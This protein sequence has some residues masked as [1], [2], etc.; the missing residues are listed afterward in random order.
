[1]AS[2]QHDVGPAEPVVV[3]PHPVKTMSEEEFV[4]WCDEDTRAEWVDGEVVV[5]SP[6]NLV[7]CKLNRFLLSV[8][9]DFVDARSL[10]E[11]VGTEFSVRLNSKRRRLPDVLF[12]A[13][14][15]LGNLSNTH[16]EGPPSLIIEIVSEDSVDR[17]WRDKYL[18]YQASGMDEY[19][20]VDPL[21]RRIQAYS[22]GAEKVY[23]GIAAVDG[24]IASTVVPGFYLRPEWLWQQPRSHVSAVLAEFLGTPG[25]G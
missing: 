17:D 21:Y 11:V 16:F 22:L 7:H 1:M 8:L 12:V 5:M 24:K 2:I 14:E 9:G 10:G 20:I 23:R 25:A 18:E 4:A 13:N 19:W 3:R 15:R 6:A